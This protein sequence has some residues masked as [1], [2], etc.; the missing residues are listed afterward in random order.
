MKIEELKKGQKILVECEFDSFAG[1]NQAWVSIQGDSGLAQLDDI[2]LDQPKPEVPQMIFD[3]IESFDDDVD[4]LH[5]HMGCQ[6][7]EVRE[8]LTHNE[9][10]FYEAW[11]AYPNITVEKEKL[12]NVK[13]LG[14]TLFKMTSDNHVRYKLI[15][16]NETPSESKFGSYKFEA[17]LT[18]QEI[19]EAD[20]RLWQW[21]KE[22]TE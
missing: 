21:K 10:D 16:E 1:A 17:D 19:K 5:E 8:W 20:E 6:S 2:K 18:E 11:L 12:Y 14:C 3:V 13:V 7:D 22:V 9:R 4:Y 15:G